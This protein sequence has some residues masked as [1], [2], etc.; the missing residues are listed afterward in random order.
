MR[1]DTHS[2]LNTATVPKTTP[3]SH[4]FIIP[5]QGTI[6][7]EISSLAIRRPGIAEITDDVGDCR[8]RYR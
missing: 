3:N 7:F 5:G 2:T 6:K 4:L 8:R 1:R